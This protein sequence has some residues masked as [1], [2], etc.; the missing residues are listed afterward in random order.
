MWVKGCRDFPHANQETNNVVESYHS[1]LKTNFLS[2]RRK[3]CARRMDWL[4]YI[5]L[6]NVEPCYR[7]KEILKKE[8]YLN[9]YKKEKQLESSIEK[10]RRIPDSDCK[11][12][13]SISHAYWV[14]SQTKP[15]KKYLVT[16]YR[17]N[18]IACD[19]PWS[20]HNNICKHAIKVDWLYSS[21]G[22]SNPLLD[23]DATLNSFNAPPDIS[24]EAPSLDL[25]A[26]TTI[27]ARDNVDQDVEGLQ[28][29]RE[30]LFGYLELLRNN[31][32]ATLS[33]TQQLIGLVKRML[34]DANN[35]DIMDYD[36]TLGL[37]ALET[38]LKRKKSFLIPKKKKK[39]SNKSGRL[40]TDSASENEPFHFP[41]LN[42]WGRPRAN[43]ASSIVPGEFCRV[44]R[45]IC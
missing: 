1:Y 17:T 43:N 31:P 18:F 2:D 45:S 20:I 15:N 40:E 39:R 27:M 41:H 8:G 16:W 26:N 36:F 35:L 24:I 6:T 5:L 21:L 37:G 14:R 38:S 42:K 25:D 44:V 30:E 12:H 7:F 33:K 11:P 9:N 23:Q 34:D 19:F 32:P 29:A 10:A 13:E 28:L 22:D 4:F 3:K